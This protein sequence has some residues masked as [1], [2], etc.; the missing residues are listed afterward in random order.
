MAGYG[1]D[2]PENFIAGALRG[3]QGPSNGIKHT[4]V[5]RPHQVINTP[6][7][8]DNVN[9]AM[10]IDSSIEDDTGFYGSPENLKHSLTG[11]SAASDEV[12]A[13]GPVKHIIIPNH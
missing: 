7:G 2:K 8:M 3:G 9:L 13:A 6:V 12:G 10:D 4:P 11:S 1:K 5:D